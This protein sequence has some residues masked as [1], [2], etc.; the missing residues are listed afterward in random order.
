MADIFD[1]FKKIEKT[2]APTGEPIT[3]LIVGLGNPGKEYTFTRH[4]AGF[5][6][7][8]YAAEK[9]GIKVDR[10][11]FKALVGDGMIGKH[12]VLLMKPQTYMNL[13]GEAVVEAAAFYKIPMENIIVICDDINLAPGKVRLRRKGSDGGQRGLRS[14]ITLSGSDEFPRIR[15]GVGAK[16]H[17]DYDLA[18]WVLGQIPKEEQEVFFAAMGKVVDTLPTILDGN[19]DKAMN[20]LN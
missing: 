1:L 7:L 6:T 13:S 16:P 5:M 20:M 11:K 19:I 18:D 14:I 17:P 3:H 10:A 4:N 12:R 15:M 2:P 8:D 9:L